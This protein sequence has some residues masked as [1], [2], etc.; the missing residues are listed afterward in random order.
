MLRRLFA[1]SLFSVLALGCTGVDVRSAADVRVVAS[2]PSPEV[3]ALTEAFFGG[4]A[5][6]A[7]MD[8][9]LRDA[10]QKNPDSGLLHEALAYSALLRSDD[11]ASWEHF[12]LAA[13]DTHNPDAALDI[14]ELG[15]VGRTRSEVQA[16]V[17]T[18]GRIV[19][20]NAD[21]FVKAR[22]RYARASGLRV[23]G[24]RDEARQEVARLGFV[25][26]VALLGAFD[27]EDGKGLAEAY[28]PESKVDLTATVPGSAVPIRWRT[29][30][31]D[32]AHGSI[33]LHEVVYPNQGAVAYV[34]FWVDVPVAM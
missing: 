16:N 28:P 18:L 23:I 33:P 26:S 24:R 13:A 7:E 34:A 32:G 30:E 25:T 9:K 21:A 20:S 6:P 17:D 22:A 31:V 2:A 11:H 3:D 12:L 14:I 27:N 10:L 5:A 15:R 4:D 19:E 29:A 1:L 8:E